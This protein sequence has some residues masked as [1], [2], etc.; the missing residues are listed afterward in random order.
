M[1]YD[2]NPIEAIWLPVWHIKC[3]MMDNAHCCL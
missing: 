1:E 3:T 2:D